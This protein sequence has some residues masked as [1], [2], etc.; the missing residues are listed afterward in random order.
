VSTSLLNAERP[1]SPPPRH[2]IAPPAV[3]TWGPEACELGEAYGI[4]AL[5]WQRLVLD[6]MLAER[7]DGKWAARNSGLA[8]PRQNGKS[9]VSVLRVLAGL[10][11]LREELIV[12]T[13]H[14]VGTAKEIFRRLV[15]VIED[16]PDLRARLKKVS[17]ARGDEA[18]ELHSPNQRL[19]VKARS[20]ESVRG[21]SADVILLDEAQMG[22]DAD[23][24]AALGP[25][26]RARPNPQ[27]VFMGTPALAP[28]TYWGAMRRRALANE[29]RMSWLEWSP[30]AGYDR[31]DRHLWWLT[32]PAHGYLIDDEAIEQD[33]LTLEGRFDT[34]ALGV[35]PKENDE[36]GWSAI[37]EG[38]WKAVQDPA[39]GIKGSPVYCVETSRDLSTI[40]IAAAGEREDGLI[41]LELVDRFPTDIGKLVGQLKKRIAKFEPLAI[42]VD[43]A[44]PAGHL[45]NDIQKHCDVDVVK[46]SSRAVAAACGSVY[47]GISSADPE[48]RNIRIRPHPGL[49]AAAR[50]AE[51]RDRGDAKIFDRRNETGPD[52][53][54]LMAAALAYWGFNEEA[55]SAWV[56]F[57]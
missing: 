3:R 22:L 32:N 4:S 43:P 46:P 28:G 24:M 19:L 18:I 45:I 38:D 20:K 35:W 16:N 40:S 34:E 44:G 15:E 55:S 25:T 6:D 8:V 47:V 14:Q 52:V 53:S 37:K 26:Q 42:V 39:S 27:L 33:L 10:Y 5:P 57:D 23:D 30:P 41:H 7:P 36:A 21:F 11:I 48:S 17:F 49:D 13:A 50:A 9:V 56:F 31:T 29:K 54:P 2:R 1:T 51:W 12:Y